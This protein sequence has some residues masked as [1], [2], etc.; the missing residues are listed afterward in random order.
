MPLYDTAIKRIATPTEW[1]RLHPL[2]CHQRLEKNQLV[3]R[4]RLLSEDGRRVAAV[5]N[6]DPSQLDFFFDHEIDH[7][8]GML[9]VNAARQCVLAASHA[10]YNVPIDYIALLDWMKVK[11]CAYGELHTETTAEATV[12][13]HDTT[14]KKTFVFN[15]VIRQGD[16]LLMRLNGRLVMLHPRLGGKVRQMTV[17]L[18]SGA[19]ETYQ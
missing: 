5:L 10:I 8:P 12:D 16:R 1:I 6:L 19:E 11:F 17:P 7:L 4:V 2:H 9:L 13:Y 14:K 3:E 18:Y 15:G